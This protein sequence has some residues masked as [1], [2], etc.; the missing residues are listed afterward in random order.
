MPILAGDLRF[1]SKM[2]RTIEKIA[3]NTPKTKLTVQKFILSAKHA[4][5]ESQ[6]TLIS[7][8]KFPSN[9]GYCY[10]RKSQELPGREVKFPL[11]SR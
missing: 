3:W 4:K 10:T 9:R 5:C 11:S 6:F 7:C 2:A 8:Q 1:I